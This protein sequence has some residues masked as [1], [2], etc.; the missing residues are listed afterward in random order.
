MVMIALAWELFS[1]GII[2]LVYEA[3]TPNL[4]CDV[5]PSDERWS[6]KHMQSYKGSVLCTV[7]IVS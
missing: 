6:Y 2:P 4:W 3:E 5:S 7:G 1:S